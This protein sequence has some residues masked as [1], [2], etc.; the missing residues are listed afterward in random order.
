MTLRERHFKFMAY[1]WPLIT[2]IAVAVATLQLLIF[3]PLLLMLSIWNG[4][5]YL[6]YA[7][8]NVYSAWG[9]LAL[10]D[11]LCPQI[12]ELRKELG[13]DSAS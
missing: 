12:D 10:H 2:V 11:Y 1:W 4:D 7:L 6:V 3:T 5:Q 8:L 9:I 13:Y